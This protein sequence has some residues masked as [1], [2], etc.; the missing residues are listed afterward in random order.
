MT[1]IGLFGF[2]S[3]RDIDK[4]AK[5]KFKLGTTGVPLLTEHVLSVLEAK[6]VDLVNVGTHTIFVGEILTGEVLGTCDALTYDYYHK[7]L[8]GKTPKSAPSYVESDRKNEQKQTK[9]EVKPMKRYVC[10]VCG[11]LYDPQKGDPE[12][13]IK[14]GTAFEDLPPNW[15]CPA[16][17]VGKD[18][19]EPEE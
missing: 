16:C 14:P 11:Y 13:G 19:F 4:F 15:T 1:L 2:R 12:N 3:G 18:A 5:V 8:R 17:G 9:E 10:S 7:H 6:V